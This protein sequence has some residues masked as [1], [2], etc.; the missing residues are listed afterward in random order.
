M[1]R[2]SVVAGTTEENHPGC[3][4]GDTRIGVGDSI[5][6]HSAHRLDRAVVHTATMGRRL[7]IHHWLASLGVHV[8]WDFDT[9]IPTVRHHHGPA[10]DKEFVLADNNNNPAVA[11]DV[12]YVARHRRVV[13]RHDFLGRHC[14]QLDD[15]TGRAEKMQAG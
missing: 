11:A 13:A 1:Q 9:P 7:G 8:R 5:A 4:T 14:T 15:D 6:R 10:E 12:N 2:Y 3:R